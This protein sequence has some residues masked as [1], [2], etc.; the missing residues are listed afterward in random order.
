MFDVIVYLSFRRCKDNCINRLSLI[1]QSLSRQ[2]LCF[3]NIDSRDIEQRVSD[4]E[5]INHLV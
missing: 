4:L 1:F 3:H 5:I 2:I